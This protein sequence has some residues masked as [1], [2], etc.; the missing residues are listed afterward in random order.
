MEAIMDARPNEIA[1]IV[2]TLNPGGEWSNWL[3]AFSAQSMHPGHVLVIDSSSD[4]DTARLSRD[5]GAEVHVIPRAQFGHGQ[6]RQ[7]GVQSV[8]EASIVVFLTQDAVLAHPEALENLMASFEDAEVGAAYGRQLPR[9]D[10]NPIEAHARLFNYPEMSRV[11]SLG[12]AP[13]LGV[14]T[15]F[16]SNSFAAYRRSALLEVGGFPSSTILC[17]DTYVAAKMLLRGWKVAYCADAM[18][19]HSHGYGVVN[20]FKRYFDLGVFYGRESWIRQNFGRT[21]GEGM[22]Y[23]RSELRYLMKRSPL[24]IPSAI[25]RTVLKLAGYKLGAAERRLPV[26]LKRLMGTNPGYWDAA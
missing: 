25:L 23:V 3:Q 2:P 8:P 9:R 19:F 10:A 12:D 1:L 11:K 18:V 24:L 14:K 15:T 6:T 22:R 7:L 5:A 21:E 17:E 4:D 13:E 20:E 26:W 16:I